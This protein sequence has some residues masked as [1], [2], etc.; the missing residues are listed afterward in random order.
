V[1]KLWSPYNL[2]NNIKHWYDATDPFDN[3][4]LSTPRTEP[5]EDQVAGANWTYDTYVTPWVDKSLTRLDL[6]TDT[7][8]SNSVV[9]AKTP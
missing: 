8:G 4:S 6:F 5:P 9:Q 3:N 7:S 2:Y 1:S